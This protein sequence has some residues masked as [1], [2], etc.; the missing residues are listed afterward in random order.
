MQVLIWLSLIFLS[1]FGIYWIPF[2]L[3]KD[4]EIVIIAISISIVYPLGVMIDHI[5]D[6]LLKPLHNKIKKR[7]PD[8]LSTMSLSIK[9]NSDV[10][11]H[12]VYIRKRIRLMRSLI[13]NVFFTI[14]ATN[15]FI[16]TQLSKIEGYN[17]LTVSIIISLSGIL[18][19]IVSYWAWS[20]LT[21]AYYKKVYD[22]SKII[23]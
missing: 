10:I 18:T 17:W 16:A 21:I 15:L 5:A 4:F 2:E 12:F 8:K 20:D 6:A 9:T 3:L 14:F 1:F 19:L 23:K 11:S 22:A 13:V 7:F